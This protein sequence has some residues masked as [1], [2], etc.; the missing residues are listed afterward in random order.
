VRY[1]TSTRFF[2]GEVDRRGGWGERRY[3]R[4][5]APRRII[6]DLTAPGVMAAPARA[7]YREILTGK[8]EAVVFVVSL[9]AFAWT[10]ALMYGWA[11]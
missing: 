10:L 3:N 5:V 1:G 11:G 7:P 4:L 9:V 6:R 2:E 8:Q